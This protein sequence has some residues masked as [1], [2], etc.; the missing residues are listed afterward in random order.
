M[1]GQDTLPA[2]SGPDMWRPAEK[3]RLYWIATGDSGMSS[4]HSSLIKE[5]FLE[6]E[7]KVKRQRKRRRS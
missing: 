3:E 5:D 2:C 7:E 1:R 6:E 4:L